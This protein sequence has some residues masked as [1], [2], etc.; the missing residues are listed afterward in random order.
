MGI[1]MD[2]INFLEQSAMM[3]HDLFTV[4]ISEETKILPQLHAGD[5]AFVR[6]STDPF[7]PG[8]IYMIRKD[9]EFHFRKCRTVSNQGQL[10]HYEFYDPDRSKTY[11]V[12][13]PGAWE[14]MVVGY[15]SAIFRRFDQ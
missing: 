11:F 5:V 6:R 15:V 10:L 7:Q 14:K 9:G 2:G 3:D 13:R 8:R 12:C 1:W 4:K